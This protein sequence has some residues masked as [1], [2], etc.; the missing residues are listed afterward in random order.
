MKKGF[1]LLE[2]LLA[3]ALLA[4]LTGVVVHHYGQWSRSYKKVMHQH[5]AL[6]KLMQV[7]EKKTANSFDV[8]PYAITKNTIE[9][10]EPSGSL[11]SVPGIQCPRPQC[12]EII[13]FWGEDSQDIQSVSVITGNK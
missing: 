7:I 11:I 6:G 1:F 9:L 13:A 3:C 12:F 8:S 4:L 2:A 10:D 5:C